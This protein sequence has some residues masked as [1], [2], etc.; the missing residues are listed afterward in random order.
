MT[1]T[2]P[3]ATSTFP[4]AIAEAAIAALETTFTAIFGEK[5]TREMNADQKHCCPCVAGI[6]SFIGET[7]W[8]LTWVL[9][10]EIAPVLAHKFTGFEIP[11]DS[12]DMGEM[13][14]ELVNVLAGDVVAQ[15]EKRCIKAQMSLPTVARGDY[16]EFTPARGPGV[17]YIDLLRPTANSGFASSPPNVAH[18]PDD[19]LARDRSFEPPRNQQPTA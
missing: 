17:G 4:A 1:A 2:E 8:S 5:P 13:A 7:S 19:A 12:P 9:P 15:L 11:F 10:R 18:G 16:L 3:N 14:A 6:I